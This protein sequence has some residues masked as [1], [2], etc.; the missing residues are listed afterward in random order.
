MAIHGNFPFFFL[1]TA[2]RFHSR[3]DE[4]LHRRSWRMACTA[5]LLNGGAEARWQNVGRFNYNM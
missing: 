4:N 5:Y 3:Q 1:V 2:S